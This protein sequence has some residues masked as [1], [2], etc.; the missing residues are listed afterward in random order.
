MVTTAVDHIR[1]SPG[2]WFL[3]MWTECTVGTALRP[4]RRITLQPR[5]PGPLHHAPPKA[6]ERMRTGIIRK[7]L[8]TVGGGLSL[9]YV[10]GDARVQVA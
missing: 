9:E 8:E 10:T 4:A 2:T 6:D 7:Y 1:T 3:G 5:L